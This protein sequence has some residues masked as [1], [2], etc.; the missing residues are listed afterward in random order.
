MR[1]ERGGAVFVFAAWG[2]EFVRVEVH[3]DAEGG[4]G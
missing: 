3:A 2:E 1:E 4:E